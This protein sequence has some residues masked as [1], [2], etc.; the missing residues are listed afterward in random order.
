MII[1]YRP[2]TTRPRMGFK[3]IICARVGKINK[4]PR[5]W[6]KAFKIPKFVWTLK[7]VVSSYSYQQQVIL[8]KSKR[9]IKIFDAIFLHTDLP[10]WSSIGTDTH[11]K[12]DLHIQRHPFPSKKKEPRIRAFP[13]TCRNKTKICD[14][15]RRSERRENQYIHTV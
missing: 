10:T 5:D 14:T 11:A 15:Y 4:I 2:L 8:N 13:F 7:L 3:L 12:S 6:G 9:N 1:S